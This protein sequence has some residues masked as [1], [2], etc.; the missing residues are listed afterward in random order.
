M[1]STELNFRFQTVLFIVKDH[2]EK[3]VQLREAAKKKCTL[4]NGSAPPPRNP[5]TPSLMAVGT[6]PSEKKQV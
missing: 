4:F 5:F 3:I 6:S 2:V 1:K